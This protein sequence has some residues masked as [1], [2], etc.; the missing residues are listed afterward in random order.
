MIKIL[1]IPLVI[2]EMCALGK[3]FV[4]G[5]V[6]PLEEIQAK[7]VGDFPKKNTK[8]EY[9][10]LITEYL[11]KIDNKGF[12]PGVREAVLSNFT[13]EKQAEKF[14]KIYYQLAGTADNES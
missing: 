14:E 12:M 10:S 13:I 4:Y 2:L 1:E 7:G 5:N 6:N 8:D 9:V 11:E 3:P